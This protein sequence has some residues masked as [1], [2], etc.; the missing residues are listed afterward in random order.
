MA[1]RIAIIGNG[2]VGSAI[3]SGLR[4]AG[5]EVQDTGHDPRRVRELAAWGDVIVLAVPFPQVDDVVREMRDGYVGKP[6][7]DVTNV[8]GEGGQPAFDPVAS[9]AEKLAGKARGARVVKAFNTVFA[10]HMDKGQVRGEPLALLAASDDEPAKR[11]VMELGQAI[12]FDPVD[13]GP[14]ENARWLEA[15]GI[16][17]IRLGY[18]V[19]HGRDV[20]FR[21][22][23]ASAEKALPARRA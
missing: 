10:Q 3:G 17:N 21:Y 11:K 8:L 6:L 18:A 9:G 5:Y 22:V 12:G 2:N 14:L 16:L 1:D 4:R 7:V 20:G 13:A 15:L 19:G 23:H